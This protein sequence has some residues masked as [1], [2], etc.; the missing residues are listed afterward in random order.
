MW[1]TNPFKPSFGSRP[2]VIVGRNE[3]IHDLRLGFDEGPGSPNRAMTVVGPRG[4]GKTV[5]LEEMNEVAKRDGWISVSAT[6]GAQM[7]IDILDQIED[8]AKRKKITFPFKSLGV[9]VLGFG[10]SATLT[11]DSES[12]SGWRFRIQKVLDT[13]DKHGIGLFVTI[14]EVHPGV[15]EVEY[16]CKAVISLS[17]LRVYPRL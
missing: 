1:T 17:Y 5:L 3:L 6:T 9:N 8:A 12:K 15:P 4:I 16:F 13:L 14:D 7:L 10:G 2:P 11:D